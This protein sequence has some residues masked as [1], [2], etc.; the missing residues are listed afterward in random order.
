M[1]Y[2]TLIKSKEL[3]DF[4]E[5]SGGNYPARLNLVPVGAEHMRERHPCF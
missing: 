2:V 1:S 5:K 4:V 3:V